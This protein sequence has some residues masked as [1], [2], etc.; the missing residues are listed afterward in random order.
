M[1]ARPPDEV[2]LASLS[3]IDDAIEALVVG[4]DLLELADVV[5]DD[6]EVRQTWVFAA[7][8]TFVARP[9]GS[10]FLIGI[11]ADQDTFLPSTLAERVLHRGCTRVLEPQ[12]DENLTEKAAGTWATATLRPCLAQIIRETKT[13]PKCSVGT[14][15]SL[16][17]RCLA[18]AYRTLRFSIPRA[19]SPTTEVDGLFRQTKTACLSPGALKN[20]ERRSG[21]WSN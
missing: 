8:P 5:I 21:V 14:S 16:T 20:S 2:R 4:G 18:R 3:A 1:P 15:G 11:I 19:P 7:P 10:V 9:S 12:P 13:P 6:S 17:M